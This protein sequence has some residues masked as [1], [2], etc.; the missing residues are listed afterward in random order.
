MRFLSHEILNC[1]FLTVAN[2][3]QTKKPMTKITPEYLE[4]LIESESYSNTG[5]TTVCI[6]KLK[7]S[8]EVV[9]TSGIIDVSQFNEEL[10]NKF[11]RE[12]AID[13]LWEL[14][15]YRLQWSLLLVAD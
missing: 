1:L 8:F 12:I 13:K 5:K 6:L 9:G 10:G 2:T 11:A 7:N 15:G 4:T 14:E 3:T